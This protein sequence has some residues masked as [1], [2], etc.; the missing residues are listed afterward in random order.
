ML[1]WDVAAAL[2]LPFRRLRDAMNGFSLGFLDNLTGIDDA[3]GVNGFFRCLSLEELKDAVARDLEAL[4]NT[5]CVIATEIFQAWPE[6]GKSILAYGINDFAGLSLASTDDRAKICRSIE[7]GI[8]RY[9]PRLKNVQATLEEKQGSI[10]KLHFT[11]SALLIVS[12]ASEPVNF[13]AVLQPST[14]KY[15][16]SRTHRAMHR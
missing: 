2:R 8:T 14:L 13:D 6:C 16:I 4:L 3:K 11:I 9:E 10:N 7:Y 5:R 1:I 15:S 12:S